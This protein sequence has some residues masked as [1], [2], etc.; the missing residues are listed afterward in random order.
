VTGD[1]FSAGRPAL[2]EVGVTFTAHVAAFELMKIRILNGGHAA[3]AY[4]ARLLGVSFVHE[5][6]RDPLIRPFLDKLALEEIIPAVPPV[7]GVDLRAY[8]ALVADR[9]ANPAVADTIARLAA[10]GSNRQ[11]KFILPSTRDRLSAGADPTGL[12]LVSALWCR[13]C[14]GTDDGDAP[15]PLDDPRA[16]RLVPAARAAR[17]D[18]GAFLAL[19]DVFADLAHAPSFRSRFA[20]ALSSLW[21]EGTRATL[22]RYLDGSLA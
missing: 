21:R 17:S 6:M 18:P 13:A 3:I 5:A 7:P 8:Y 10:D 1:R 14:A 9:F 11:P 15:L 12:A 20:A 16:A 4:P 22:R 19:S 2:E